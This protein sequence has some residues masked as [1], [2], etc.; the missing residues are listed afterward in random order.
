VCPVRIPLPR[1]MRNW[2]EQ[3][4]ARHLSPAPVRGGLRLWG[5]FAA[6]PALYRTATGLA[7]RMLALAGRAKGRFASLPFAGGWTAWRDMPAPQGAT[8]Q[9]QWQARR[10][11]QR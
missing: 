1:M 10:R 11:G 3:E 6:R 9:A 4:F 7:T 2:R 5:F 8:F